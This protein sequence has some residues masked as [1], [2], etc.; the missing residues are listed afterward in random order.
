MLSIRYSN[1]FK[2]NLELMIRRGNDPEKIRA[3]IV[4]ITNGQILEPLAK[5]THGYHLVDNFGVMATAYCM[6][7]V[8]LQEA[9]LI[10]I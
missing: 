2:K 9:L 7:F 6:S 8:V 5:L 3:V 1:K 10:N 4:A